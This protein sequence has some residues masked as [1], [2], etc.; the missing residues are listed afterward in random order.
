MSRIPI[1]SGVDDQKISVDVADSSGGIN[2]RFH[3]TEI[4]DNQMTVAYN[5][6]ITTPGKKKKRMGCVDVLNDLGATPINNLIYL[7]APGVDPRMCVQFNNRLYKSTDPLNESGS[8][9]DI[10][11]S[12]HFDNLTSMVSILA[13]DIL[14]FTN[15]TNN[16]FS[17]DGTSITDEGNTNT[18]PPRAKCLTYFKN[19]LWAANTT[20]LPDYV[21]YSNTLAPKVF[22]RSVQ[23]FKVSTG[24]STGVTNMVP[25]KDS[26]IVIFK[27]RS[28]H[29]LLVSGDTAAY[30]NLRPVDTKYGCVAA[31]CAKFHNDSIYF[32]SHDGI[33]VIPQQ[34]SS[35][36]YLIKTE[37]DDI[38][39]AY[40]DRC[41]MTIFND[42]LFLAVPTGNSAYPNKV[43]VLDLNTKG[44]VT[45]TGWN[46]GCWGTYISGGREV[47]MYGDAND[48]L[49]YKCF[50]AGQFNDVA[51]KINYQEETKAFH[52][53]Q[54]FVYKVG[55]EIEVEISSGTGNTVTVSA[56]IDGGSYTVL[57]T[58]TATARFQL[59][60]LGKFKTVKFKFQND[61]TS[62]EQLV[63]NGFRV[64]TYPEEYY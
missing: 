39:G 22:D 6:D 34:A 60:V 41:R 2:T 62:S 10:D 16:V 48:G 25:Y 26:S 52:F 43:Y 56:A 31:D 46:V 21:W 53:G 11:S 24:D 37:M 64:I 47:L 35:V 50:T 58:C 19:K 4:Q 30:W 45:F 8:W 15:G 27:E 1:Y 5:I 38:N 61:A 18:T 13:G 51:T 17:Y 36:S 7:K 54:P 33:R 28:I 32:L 49:V 42:M 44:M 55:G 20:A 29:E 3:E 12:D 63:F 23:V 59:D 9:I 14:F 40:I 57:G